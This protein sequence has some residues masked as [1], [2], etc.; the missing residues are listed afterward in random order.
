MNAASKAELLFERRGALALVTLNRPRTLNALTLSMFRGLAVQVAAWAADPEVAAVVITGAGERAFCAG[1][2][3]IE[4]YDSARGDR[5]LAAELFRVEYRLNRDLFR[6]PKPTIALIDGIVMGGGVGISLHG[7][8]RVATER[9]LFAMP[10]TAIGL[11]PDV[12]GSYF[13]PRLPGALGLYLGLTGARLQA[14]D[15][16]YA[17][18]ATHYVESARL[19]ALVDALAAADWSGDARAVASDAIAA[20]ASAPGDPPLAVQRAAIDRC[21]SKASVEAILAALEAEE[22]AWAESA[23]AALRKCSPT[24]LK[25]TFRQL[26]EGA[27]LDFE[28]AMIME[29]RL[30]QACVAGHD[31][32]EGIRAAVIDKD[33]APRW[34][35]AS[36]D[37]VDEA[38]V[39]AHFAPPEDGDLV[40]D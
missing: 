10:E 25:V 11:F 22:G 31:F 29:Y 20:F 38:L 30:S 15:C 21:F 28:D 2:D 13:L 18:I 34:C 8:H 19:P 9:T 16:L 40:F 14:A 6:Y 32:V 3:V 1:G 37:E 23:L 17:G 12:G 36:L 35:P 4:V 39:A 26:R 33:R 7:S 5:K 24:S 27:G